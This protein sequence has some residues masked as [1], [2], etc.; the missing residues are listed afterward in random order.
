MRLFDLTPVV[1]V[2]EWNI[3]ANQTFQI[4]VDSRGDCAS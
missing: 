2:I 1:F 4:A 3:D